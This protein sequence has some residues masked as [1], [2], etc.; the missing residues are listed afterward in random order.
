MFWAV[1]KEYKLHQKNRLSDKDEKPDIL[2]ILDTN[3]S[4]KKKI[5]HFSAH[6]DKLG[7]LCDLNGKQLCL[8]P[9]L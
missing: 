8:L 9:Y 5:T 4:V 1:I 3:H 2:I 7:I 6:T